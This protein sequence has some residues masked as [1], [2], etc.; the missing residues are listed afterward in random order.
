MVADERSIVR[1]HLLLMKKDVVARGEQ[2]STFIARV[3]SSFV[4]LTTVLL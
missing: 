1:M 2:L 3:S 4:R